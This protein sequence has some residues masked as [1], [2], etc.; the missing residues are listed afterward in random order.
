MKK[1]KILMVIAAFYPY[2][3]GAEKQ[4]QKL[5]CELVK[6]GVDVTVVTG[7]W[8][9]NLKK[10]EEIDGLKVIRN[11][12]NFNF[13]KKEKI[14][15]DRSFFYTEPLNKKSIKKSIKI[16]LR[17]IFVR[18]SVYVYQFSLFFFLIS[19]RRQYDI[20]HV[21]Q[22]LYPAY[23]ST[24]CARI[25]K[26]PVIAKVGSSG[27]NSDI[28]Q[29]KELP[30]G[31][32]QLRYILKNIDRIICTSKVMIE[33][34]VEEGADRDKIVLIRN[35]VNITDFT[36][37]YESCSTLATM[38]RFIKS[39]NIDT[40]IGAFSKLVR[41]SSK[42]LKLILIGDG[43]EKDN[44]VSL[45]NKAGLE[46]RVTLTGMVDNPE[47]F[48][49]KSDLFVFPSLVEGLSNSLIEAMSFKLPCIVSSIPGN[50][51]VL[52]DESQDNKSP[53]DEFQGDEF[54]GD[55]NSCYD[56]KNGEFKVTKCGVFF[57]PCDVDGLVNAI[58]YVMDNYE[59]RKKLGENAYRKI[60]SEY[61]IESIADRYLRLYKEI[62]K[63]NKEVLEQ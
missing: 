55:D 26:K 42:D 40:L 14:D 6:K 16:I 37:S 2:T 4:A 12:T 45:I 36:R 5:A 30:G 54:P 53:D 58:S 60:L 29:I 52:G 57:N 59:I 51:E 33:E 8:D 62:L 17:K 56:I 15:T 43:P 7:R 38:G 34:F 3:G 41:S 46:E 18:L 10:T 20:I 47:D 39:K 1:L 19:H 13:R 61:N 11:L 63:Q 25:L 28:N 23:I 21:H 48:L 31:G 32:L 44:I 49:K 27:S 50:I 24:L 35:G 22:V 9:N